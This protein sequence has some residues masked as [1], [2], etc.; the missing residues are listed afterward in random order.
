M[1]KQVYIAI[2]NHR[3]YVGIKEIVYTLQSA[4]SEHVSVKLTRELKSNCVNIIIDEFSGIFDVTVIKRTKEL[5]PDTKIVI[6]AT[7]FVTPVRFFGA[8]LTKTFN[9]FGSPRDWFKFGIGALRPLLGGMPSYMQ[10][11]YLGFVQVLAH[12]DL[13]TAVHPSI[14]PTVA[15]LTGEFGLAPPLMVYPQIGPLPV[16]QLN[17][18]WHLP[19]GFTMTGTQTR[20]RSRIMRDL[21]RKFERVG[22]FTPLFKRLP[23]ENPPADPLDTEA[24]DYMADYQSV[25]PDYLF[26]INPPQTANW[27][28]SSPMRILRAILLGQIPVVTK[29]FHDHLIEAVAT[30]WDGRVDTAVDLGTRQFLDRRIWLTDYMRLI[31]DYDRQAREANRPFVDAVLKL[32]ESGQTAATASAPVT[33]LSRVAERR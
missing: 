1:P 14:V 19:V 8:G 5:Y 4:L 3:S 31:E 23:F 7:E 15:D 13:L 24:E 16:V 26:N 20:Y 33:N 9:F 30:L 10:L 12:C 2:G 22:W 27:A 21:V 6:T 18:L 32:A 28:Y 25:S 11:R 29:K 17:R